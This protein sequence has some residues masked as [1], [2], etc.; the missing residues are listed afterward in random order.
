[1]TFEKLCRKLLIKAGSVTAEQV[2]AFIAAVNQLG[3]WD[4]V[5]PTD[6][7]PA[8]N[9]AV[10]N[11]EKALMLLKQ[12]QRSDFY[13]WEEFN[14]PLVGAVAYIEQRLAENNKVKPEGRPTSLTDI[15]LRKLQELKIIFSRHFPDLNPSFNP[16]TTLH[17]IGSAYLGK[18]IPRSYSEN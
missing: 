7:L 12:M 11:S 1:M 15:E 10:K 9:P 14:D 4:C 13:R 6:Y 17:R 18:P 5:P 16:N 8:T 2:E 3:I